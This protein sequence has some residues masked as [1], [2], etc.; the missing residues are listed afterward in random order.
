MR[1]LR[2]VQPNISVDWVKASVPYT[3]H[4]MPR[5][6]EGLQKAGLTD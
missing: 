3:H 5:F 4:T 6:L 2:Q 1:L